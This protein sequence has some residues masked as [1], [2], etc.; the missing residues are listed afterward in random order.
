[1]KIATI[2]TGMIAEEFL[3]VQQYIPDIEVTALC[4]TERSYEKGVALQK[5]Y[6]VNEVFSDYTLCLE[7]GIFDT[8]YIATPNHLHYEQALNALIKGKNVICEKPFALH[9]EE[10]TILSS[11]AD[12]SKLILVEAIT[13]QYLENYKIIKNYLS[14]I[15]EIRVVEF[16]YSQYSSR[17]D[18]FR[19]G[20]ILPAF[21]PQKGGGALRDLNVYN[22]HL[23][24]GLFGK[25]VDVNY[26]GNIKMDIDTSGILI[27][28]Y[29]GF[30][31]VC[32]A[33]KDSFGNNISTIQG[34][35]GTI[36]I[37]G[38]TNTLPTIIIEKKGQKRKKFDENP[39]FHRMY[40]EF[41]EF[42]NMIKYKD[43]SYRD[44][45]LEQ[46]KAVLEIIDNA[47]KA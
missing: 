8:V 7:Q 19:K 11:L 12:Q 44:V 37:K 28:D 27:L 24:V 10:L 38:S 20:I 35:E 4:T 47:L 1:M 9:S 13:N 14:E 32:V 2:G 41:T 45:K 6:R 25:P 34:E 15:G 3:K 46:S 17:Y 36:F 26:F 21:D 42:I 29:S 30:H 43:F 5:K 31:V 40:K 23:A 22:I 39:S 33:A 18:Q 16:N